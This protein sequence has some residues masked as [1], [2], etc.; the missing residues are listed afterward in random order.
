MW[1]QGFRNARAQRRFCLALS[2][3]LLGFLHKPNSA[4]AQY[5]EKKAE[6]KE[7]QV[8][9][10]YLAYRQKRRVE[11]KELETC[12]WLVSYRHR[13][14]DLSPLSRKGLDRPLEGD[15]HSILRR[16]PEA[17][18]SLEKI[19]RNNRDAKVHTALASFA[20]VTFLGTRIAQGANEKNRRSDAYL[21][22]NIGAGLLFLRSIYA[23]FEL[24]KS[25]REELVRAVQEFNK[26]S[27]D[28]ILP[29][30]G[31]P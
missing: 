17:N 6:E 9:N 28:P 23:G 13:I 15:L 11:A 19:D 5:L 25:T 20:I 26:V 24:R 1:I 2:V 10:P 30:E 27:E 18:A 3:F 4:S 21:A 8:A 31:E 22:I 29:Y 14:Y 12:S 16:V 7:N